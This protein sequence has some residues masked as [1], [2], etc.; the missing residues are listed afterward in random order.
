LYLQNK[1]GRNN[2]YTWKWFGSHVP[3]FP[4]DELKYVLKNITTWNDLRYYNP[5]SGKVEK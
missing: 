5:Y 3:H 4:S 1:T 2:R